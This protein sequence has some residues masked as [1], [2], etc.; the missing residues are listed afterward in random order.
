MEK[1][2]FFNVSE[3]TDELGQENEIRKQDSSF[4]KEYAVELCDK[5][6]GNLWR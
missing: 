2:L 5:V 6:W 3:Y 4:T 1:T